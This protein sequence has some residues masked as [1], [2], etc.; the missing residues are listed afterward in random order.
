MVRP[1]GLAVGVA[2]WTWSFGD[3][4]GSIVPVSIVGW[5]GSCWWC[6]VVGCVVACSSSGSGGESLLICFDKVGYKVFHGL[7]VFRFV[8][9]FVDGAGELIAVGDDA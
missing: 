4:R 9:P 1:T 3:S 7:L 8:I 2:V 6:Y 5:Q